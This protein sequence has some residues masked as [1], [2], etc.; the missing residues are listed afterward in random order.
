MIYFFSTILGFLVLN[1]LLYILVH[2]SISFKFLIFFTNFGDMEI[3]YSSPHLFEPVIA[4]LATLQH[5]ECYAIIRT[6]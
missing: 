5:L 2:I 6:A 1:E 4:S 3:L